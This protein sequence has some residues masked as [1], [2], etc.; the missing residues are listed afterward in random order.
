[1]CRGTNRGGTQRFESGRELW[2]CDTNFAPP[3]PTSSPD[4]TYIFAPEIS[5]SPRL[6]DSITHFP[7]FHFPI[8]LC[9]VVVVPLP[10]VVPSPTW[11]SLEGPPAPVLVAFARLLLCLG[12]SE[13]NTQQHL[14][15][16]SSPFF[17]QLSQLSRRVFSPWKGNHIVQVR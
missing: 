7:F 9:L 1:M 11:C 17:K 8:S 3:P 14:P 5:E 4:R 16:M 10:G 12:S 2:S 15:K 6:G 13:Y